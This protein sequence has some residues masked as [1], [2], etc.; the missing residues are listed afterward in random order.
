A[1]TLY[2]S[3]EGTLGAEVLNVNATQMI[4][5]RFDLSKFKGKTPDGWGILELTSQAV[6]WS[7]NNQEEFGYLRT[8]EIKAGDPN[9]TRDSVTYDSF[10]QG[11]PELDV[12][13]GQ[14]IFD[15]LPAL[16]RAQA[17]LISINPAVLARLMS[18]ETKGLAIYPQGSLNASFS[19][20]QAP[21]PNFRPTLHFNVKAGQ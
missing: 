11:K 19:S 18:G 8:V 10:F 4:I 2:P 6:A 15:T 12:L 20:S 14:L 7:P 16:Q 3:D 17:T 21:G 9:W 1:M 13:N 5:L